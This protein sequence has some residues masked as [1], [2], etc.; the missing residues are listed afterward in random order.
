[1]TSSGSRFCA[2]P[3]VWLS[4]DRGHTH[5]LKYRAE[6][7]QR[8]AKPAGAVALQLFRRWDGGPETYVGTFTR[9]PMLLECG[10]RDDLKV[11]TYRARWIT[12]RG[13]VGPWSA[14]V[15]ARANCLNVV[16]LGMEP[17]DERGAMAA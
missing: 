15:R 1:M 2:L 3:V 4:E 11:A 7:T 8:R 6:D 9:N 5:V 17:R 12:R 14:A 10:P 16:R 13:L